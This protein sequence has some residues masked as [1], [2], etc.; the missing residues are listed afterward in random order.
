MIRFDV[1]R[2]T[3]APLTL[4]AAVCVSCGGAAPPTQAPSSANTKALALPAPPPPPD[5]S[6]VA[7]PA[8]LIAT[9]RLAKPSATLEIARSWSN[10][11]MP[12]S[13]QATELLLGDAVGPLVDLDSSVDLAV[14]VDPARIGKGLDAIE[15]GLWVA[16]AAGVKNV[17]ATKA[18]LSDRYKLVPTDNG[19][20]LIAGLGSAP[21][22]DG[23][24]DQDTDADFRRTC[25][26]A[27]AFGP[28]STRIV[29]AFGDPKA[30]ALLGPW[31]TR[32]ATRLPPGADVHVDL[33]LQPLRPML[34]E[35]GKMISALAGSLLGASLPLP[36]LRDV[37]LAYVSDFMDLLLDVD[38]EAI[39]LQLSDASARATMS[40][41]LSST[42]STMARISMSAADRAGPPPPAFWQMPADAAAVGFGRGVDDALI[43]R[44]R[45]LLLKVLGEGLA[46]EGVKA[47]DRKA[48]VDA[49]A[50]LAVIP[51][52]VVASG[53]DLD[54]AA[55]A[56]AA[57][58]AETS[59][60]VD[61]AFEWSIA[62][63]LFGWHLGEVDM[64]SAQ[65]DGAVKDL[66]A[67]WSRPGLVAA[68][69]GKL[70]DATLPTIRA[71][72]LS[73]SQ[74]PWPKGASHYVVDIAPPAVVGAARNEKGKARPA[75]KAL[76]LHLL[77]VPDGAKT[78]F[79]LSAD[80]P[81]LVARLTGA[82][83]GSGETVGARPEAASL[84]AASV[85]GA[86][87][88]SLAGF[89]AE[90][91][92][93]AALLGAPPRLVTEPIRGLQQLPHRGLVPLTITST[94]TSTTT[95]ASALV[96]VDV[97]RAFVDDTIQLAV[98]RLHF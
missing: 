39:D 17:D 29:C 11:P 93:I 42:K 47:A 33:R 80:E 87:F 16:V 13:E 3:F 46:Y 19:A 10:L 94:T 25:E 72:P 14:A 89:A 57:A 36:S 2:A 37:L 31:L 27:P 12:Q 81:A 56:M 40:V 44:P 75:P 1:A 82:M 35:Q 48:L 51:P 60:S 9:G 43:A 67:A 49:A 32:G 52:S 78:W 97:P 95:P 79:G 71:A 38:T 64:P 77:L 30:L 28:S 65:L 85:G 59:T 68:L 4:I 18:A 66:V 91:S 54:A 90:L 55:K 45:E 50:K 24:D 88:V 74:V 6:P 15:G 63:A 26:L 86:G 96:T 58:P 73:K 76:R 20:F 34:A 92:A 70:K 22:H 21:H 69:R 61:R 5:V 41:A 23:D 83:S 62:P 7:A 98:Q 84:K 53:L 8:T